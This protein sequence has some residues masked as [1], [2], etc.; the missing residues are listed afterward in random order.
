MWSAPRRT[1][2]GGQ[3]RY[4]D[5]AIETC[6]T[7]HTGSAEGTVWED[8][9]CGYTAAKERSD[10]SA[11]GAGSN[12]SGSPYCPD[13]QQWPY[14]LAGGHRAHPAQNDRTRT[15]CVRTHCLTLRL[16]ETGNSISAP[17]RATKLHKVPD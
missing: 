15:T 12:R 6:L 5:L 13:P 1:S 14:G 7:L 16:G 3:R 10:P 17:I 2:R 4:S 8:P 9:G 11:I